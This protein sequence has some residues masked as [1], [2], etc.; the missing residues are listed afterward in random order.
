MGLYPGGIGGV[1][2]TDT[3]VVYG[4]SSADL[5]AA[6]SMQT[7]LETFGPMSLNTTI[8]SGELAPVKTSSQ[9]LYLN[10]EMFDTKAT[11]TDSELPTVL[12]SGEVD[13]YDYDLKISVPT[14]MIVYGTTTDD[15][16]TPIINADFESGASYEFK[17]IFPTPVDLKDL[18][19]EAISLFGKNYEFS[20]E[21]DAL[22]VGELVLYE[23]INTIRVVEGTAEVVNGNT[24]SVIVTDKD[25]AR[26]TVNGDSRNVESGWSGVIG[27]VDLAIKDVTY[28]EFSGGIRLVDLY[29]NSQKLVLS[30]NDEVELGGE[31]IDG[32]NVVITPSG[33]D[34]IREIVITAIPEQFDD[35][36]E[37]LKL[38]DSF[39]D[40]VF[41][42]VKFSLDTVSPELKSNERDFIEIKT[43]GDDSARIEFINK[44]GGEYDFEFI[45]DNEET[46]FES[47]IKKNEYFITGKDEY[48]QIW[49]V[50]KVGVDEIEIKDMAKDSET[51]ELDTDDTMEFT[52][53]DGSVATLTSDGT[54]VNVDMIEDYLYTEDGAKIE[55]DFGIITETEEVCENYT[56][57]T[58]NVS[59]CTEE[60]GDYLSCYDEDLNHWFNFFEGNLTSMN[61][62]LMNDENY[63]HLVCDIYSYGPYPSCEYYDIEA[64]NPNDCEDMPISTSVTASQIIITEE[65]DYNGGKFTD[66][67]GHTLGTKITISI[68]NLNNSDDLEL[69][70]KGGIVGDDDNTYLLTN[71][72]TFV[73]E[74]DK[75]KVEI[76]Y[77]EEAMEIGFNIGEIESKVT[78]VSESDVISKITD[79][80]ASASSSQDIIVVGGSC[81]NS[82]AAQLLGGSYCGSEFTSMT[83]VGAGKALIQV[84][85]NPYNS[86]GKAILVAGYEQA[87]T[88]R[89]VN[90]LKV[91]NIDMSIGSKI[92]I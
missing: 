87:D 24:I 44:A 33:T 63:N 30:N 18:E 34:K 72:G 53:A 22:D 58:I 15:F 19:G 4:S 12:A 32:T 86:N 89:A 65:T 11:F 5:N 88:T 91:N 2:T 66:N 49:K 20:E 36:V 67:D 38:G 21:E 90:Y 56:E 42:T 73:K 27:D 8:T 69:N 57:N 41:G 39:I 54:S 70:L 3:S 75:D 17:I 50:E 76:Y 28:Q 43:S 78:T 60:S 13:D 62:S 6:T 26:V 23:N 61:E 83:G 9:P 55:F 77:P 68:E 45:E 85:V 48:T 79:G 64:E 47:N 31:S 40:P 16:D 29:I 71:Y 51:I 92:I 37:Y 81:I 35:E 74:F 7:Y 59:S 84:F 80:A 52:L 82:V 14:S 1:F 10:D 46:F 25:D